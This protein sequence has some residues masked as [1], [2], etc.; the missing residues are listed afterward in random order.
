MTLNDPC[1]SGRR[2]LPPAMTKVTPV[3][4]NRR[5]DGASE[6]GTRPDRRY[7]QVSC[8]AIPVALRLAE[9]IESLG[10]DLATVNN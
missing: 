3:R 7:A 6:R 5:F 4:S 9:R 1:L 8:S 10:E 2:P